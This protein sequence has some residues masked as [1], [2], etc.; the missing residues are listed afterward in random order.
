MTSDRWEYIFT[1]FD[2][3]LA[4]PEAERAAFLSDH[5][6]EDV[7]LRQEVESLLAAHG[8][9]EGFLS[10]RPARTGAA[11]VDQSGPAS[12]SLTRGKR[13]GV[14]DIESFLGA[15][16]MGE[17]YK[18][19]DTR[20]DRHVAIKVLLPDAASDPRGRARFAYEAR[21]IARLS[22]PRICALHEMGHQDG[23]DFLVM[24]YLEGETLAARLRKGPMAL[25]QALSTAVEI[26]EALAAAHAQG[27]VH[28]DLKPSNVML[29]AGGAKLLDFGL[30]RLRAPVGS[31]LSPSS[32]AFPSSE[33]A[34]GLI[35]GTLPY[36]APEQLEGNEVDARADIFAFGAVLYEMITGRKAFEGTS[37]AS[38]I[39]AILSSEP[40]AVA[41]L[42]PLTPPALD[43]V[44]HNCLAKDRNDRWASAHDVRLQLDWIAGHPSAA[45]V[46]AGVAQNPWREALAWT[47]AAMAG[48]A[49]V[50]LWAWGLR[51]PTP[52]A[53]M[54]VSSALPPPGVSLETD[55]APAI[56]PDGSRLLFVGHDATGTQL[57]YT[58]A[59]DTARPAQA[60]AHTDGAS[61][62]FWSPD[63]QSV[64]FFGQGKLKTV[65]IETGQIRTL[66][67]AGAARGGTWNRDDVIVFAPRAGTGLYRISAAGGPPTPMK[68]D[69]VGTWFP[70]FLPDGRHFLFFTPAPA[71]PQDAGVFVASLDSSAMKRLVTTRS[72]AVHAPGYLLFWREG[73]LLAQAFDETTLE[74]RGNPVAVAN[75][76]GLNAVTNQGL[77]SVSDSGTLV[78]FAGAVGESE[79]VWFDRTGRRIGSSG[80]KGV[81]NSV[82]LS[83][84]SASVIYDEAEPRNRTLD[85]WRLDFARG[86]P[87]RLTFNP[88]HDMFPL[89]SP[90]GTRIVF[91]SLREPPPQLYELNANS[92]GTEK[93]LLKTRF[94]KTASGW[95]SD[96]RLLFYDSIDPQTG[97]DVWALPMVGKPEPVLGGPHGGRRALRHA[98]ARRTVAG[99]HLERDRRLRGVR[100]I[101]SC[102]RI[103]AASFDAGRL[104]AAVAT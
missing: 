80:P 1:V 9:A 26:A 3:A 49:L 30:A 100:R 59:L 48:L 74:V 78:F 16:G 69:A 71:Q 8:D 86:I 55:E 39:S 38:V 83:P 75:A 10:G 67:D 34:P 91:S 68:I 35:A 97:G 46:A 103:Q 21:A 60:L 63:S 57:L 70:S 82:S 17:V 53:R 102:D 50:V 31:G 101:V 81:F 19:R 66:A 89:W 15:G 4:R 27:I 104:R 72:C 98:L 99:V 85:V 90:D 7:H 20:L 2:A 42:Q 95:S 76:V 24:E 47:I 11:N 14:F 94:P 61:L 6:G 12:P 56:S 44:I 84:D 79:L 25:T 77:F 36:M 40:P 52:E 41:V 65:D 43:R 37:Q 92:A 88:A 33:T 32:R 5:C 73:A 13:L 58:L 29:T 62:P 64:G 96:G 22:H 28:R 45:S 23:V 87:S 18:A 93:A 51:R 54:H